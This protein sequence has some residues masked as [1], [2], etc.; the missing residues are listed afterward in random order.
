MMR[1]LVNFIEK[2]RKEILY[3]FLVE[4]L[5]KKLKSPENL[6]IQNSIR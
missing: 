2:D 5:L 3:G 4:S 1:F 6:K